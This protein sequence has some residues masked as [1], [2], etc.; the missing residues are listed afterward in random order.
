ML[1]HSTILFTL[2]ILEIFHK[3]KFL[4]ESFGVFPKIWRGIAKD[5][6]QSALWNGVSLS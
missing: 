3:R 5:S 2:H 1:V 4:L 6:G